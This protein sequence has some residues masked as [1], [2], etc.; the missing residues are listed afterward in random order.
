MEEMLGI[1]L[2]SYLY[3]KLAKMLFFFNSYVFSSTALEKKAEQLLPGS[4]GS[5]AGDHG[6]RWSNQTMYTHMKKCIN[7]KKVNEM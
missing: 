2:Y 5:V 7:N 4:E 1:C 3:P 6:E